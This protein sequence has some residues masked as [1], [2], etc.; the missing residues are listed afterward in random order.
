VKN[1]EAIV[2]RSLLNDVVRND[3]LSWFE[4]FAKIDDKGGG[5]S[6]KVQGNVLQRRLNEIIGWLRERNLPVRIIV[7]KPRQKGSSTFA[8]AVCYC[9][10]RRSQRRALVVGK[11]DWQ[12]G[13][14]L[15]KAK[16]YLLADTFDGWDMADEGKGAKAKC[17]EFANG[18]I[19]ETATAN[20]ADSG[21][22]ATIQTFIATEVA[23]WNH[24]PHSEANDARVL[25]GSLAV[26]HE[27]A[28]T[29]VIIESTAN[30][31]SGTFYQRWRIA[32]DFD[33]YRRRYERGEIVNSAYIRVFVPWFDFEDSAISLTLAQETALANSLTEDER[34]LRDKHSISLPKIAWRRVKIKDELGGDADMFEQEYPRS[35]ETAFLSSGR[36]RFPACFLERLKPEQPTYG[37]IEES[38]G[39]HVLWRSAHG[40]ES[41]Q[42]LRWEEPRH[43]CAYLLSADICTGASQQGGKDPDCHAAFVIR[44]GYRDDAGDWHRPAIVARTAPDC[45]HDT[46]IFAEEL[47][48]LSLYYGGCIIVPELN[49]PGHAVVLWLKHAIAERGL[50]CTIYQR[51]VFNE[52][53]QRREKQYGWLT[54][55]GDGGTRR[56]LV[57]AIGAALRTQDDDGGGIDIY[58]AHLIDQLWNFVVTDSGKAEGNP[59]DDDVMA[60][61]IGLATL[62]RATK[63]DMLPRRRRPTEQLGMHMGL[64][65]ETSRI[66]GFG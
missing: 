43:G 52:R 44:Q 29:T 19:I 57:D 48:R 51:E 17:I 45:R 39:K 25:N 30:G 8:M 33:E 65:G 63:A 15:K 55:A 1:D 13:N 27:Q 18:S 53:T 47:L 23:F 20:V 12:S 41:H 22:S 10:C 14:L 56:I 28:G 38:I 3:T 64:S 5:R 31:K 59:H 16:E 60:L 4:L 54:S 46:D 2:L 42:Y 66:R 35:A 6:Q 40:R 58:D 26:V 50:P 61:G 7:L 37:V 34:D 32:L 21:R 24:N 62:P 11:K 49:N 9:D 36:L